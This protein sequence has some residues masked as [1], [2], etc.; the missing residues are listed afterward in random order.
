[1]LSN[2]LLLFNTGH[3][4]ETLRG[5]CMSK[6]AQRHNQSL[7]KCRVAV[8]GGDQLRAQI[9]AERQSTDAE[10]RRHQ[11]GNGGLARP[12]ATGEAPLSAPS[13]AVEAGNLA[14]I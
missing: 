10:C 9:H 5:R 2:V 4:D 1:M 3:F 14:T 7:G 13:T 11:R 6:A 8:A 12:A